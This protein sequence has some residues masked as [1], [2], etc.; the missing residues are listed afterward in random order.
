MVIK[1]S[2]VTLEVNSIPALPHAIDVEEEPDKTL[3]IWRIKRHLKRRET[4]NILIS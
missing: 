2:S 3:E 1:S 4:F